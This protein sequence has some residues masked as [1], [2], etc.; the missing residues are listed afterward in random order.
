MVLD[1]IVFSVSLMTGGDCSA[2][3]P[4]LPAGIVVAVRDRAAS[5]L[6]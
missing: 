2:P 5:L 4:S 3:E 6:G 1:R